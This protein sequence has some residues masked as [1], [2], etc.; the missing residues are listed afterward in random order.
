MVIN[1]CIDIYLKH[2]N[3]E[4]L[5]DTIAIGP[6]DPEGRWESFYDY[7]SKV[8]KKLSDPNYRMKFKIDETELG[9]IEDVIIH[10]R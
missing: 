2:F 6:G 9:D 7:S 4:G 10:I 1:T 3:R 8:Y 5:Y